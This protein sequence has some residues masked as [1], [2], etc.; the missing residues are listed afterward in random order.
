VVKVV[1][2]N[3]VQVEENKVGIKVIGVIALGNLLM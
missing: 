1:V 3:M 2:I